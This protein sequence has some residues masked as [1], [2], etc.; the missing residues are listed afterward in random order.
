MKL[1]YRYDAYWQMWKLVLSDNVTI[2]LTPFQGWERGD[3]ERHRGIVVRR[4]DQTRNR[5]D[6]NAEQLPAEIR[7]KVAEFFGDKVT[8][9]LLENDQ[10][11]MDLID[12]KKFDQHDDEG[13]CLYDI[14]KEDMD[15]PPPLKKLQKFRR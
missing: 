8:S 15:V 1:P 5:L 2:D 3:I 4:E 10:D 11:L 13:A 12:W 7:W 14:I 6:R 9:W